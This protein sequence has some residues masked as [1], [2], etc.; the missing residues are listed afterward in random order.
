MH[1]ACIALPVGEAAA[2]GAEAIDSSPEA[3]Q[4]QVKAEGMAV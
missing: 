3:R 1:D 2:D 4:R